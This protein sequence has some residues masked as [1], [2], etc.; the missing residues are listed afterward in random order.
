MLRMGLWALP[1]GPIDTKR[2]RT[3]EGKELW[4]KSCESVADGIRD[5]W[6]P[7]PFP[8]FQESSSSLDKGS[9]EAPD[10]LI[11][12]GCEGEVRRALSKPRVNVLLRCSLKWPDWRGWGGGWCSSGALSAKWAL[13]VTQVAWARREDALRNLMQTFMTSLSPPS[14]G[15][16]SPS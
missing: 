8:S 13:N 9:Q 6:S 10:L 16:K 1:K 7:P 3:Q 14:K 2:S 12:E 4:L 11:P 15:R 5:C